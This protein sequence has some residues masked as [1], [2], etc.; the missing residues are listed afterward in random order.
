MS[1]NP[2]DS[3][4]LYEWLREIN[5]LCYY[6]LFIEKGI[7]SLD[8]IIS[9]MKKEKFKLL[10]QDIEEIGIKKPGHIYR[11]LVKL[12]IDSEL[13]NNKIYEYVKNA[14]NTLNT[15]TNIKISKEYFCGCNI[16]N[17]KRIVNEKREIFNLGAWLRN[18]GMVNL[19]ENFM[20]NGFDMI[21]FFIIQM[22]SSIPI[23]EHI[24]KDYLHIYSEKQR[25]LIIMQLNRD[26]RYIM[27]RIDPKYSSTEIQ[28]EIEETS[29]KA[30]IIF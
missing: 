4:K 23:D 3:S 20:Y 13:I 9:D 10:Y 11:I 2:V 12:E 18:I 17:E 15:S 28:K 14:R 19:K 25:D 8:S 30:C 22:F 24:L 7:Y 29:C 21:E 5:L 6:P 26:V 16:S 27:K 1:L